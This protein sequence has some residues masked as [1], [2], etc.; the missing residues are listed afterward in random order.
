[1]S[2]TL[3]AGNKQ[4]DGT[5]FKVFSLLYVSPSYKEGVYKAVCGPP[6]QCTAPNRNLT[7]GRFALVAIQFNLFYTI[8]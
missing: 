5:I 3:Q 4:E 6:T 8:C 1:M 7:K 2:Q